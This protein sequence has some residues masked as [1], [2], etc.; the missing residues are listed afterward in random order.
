MANAKNLEELSHLAE[1]LNSQ[2]DKL[3]DSIKAL[4]VR[5]A[6]LKVGIAYWLD[7]PL[8]STGIVHGR[9]LSTPL[10]YEKNVY[11][12]YAR[13]A[14]EWQLALK[15]ETIKYQWELDSA[16]EIQKP[17]SEFEY[18]PLLSGSRDKRLKAV[19]HFDELIDG[20]TRHV[21]DKLESVKAAENFAKL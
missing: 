1:Q 16:E 13:I 19:A 15:E 10:K 8:D 6:N 9:S 7:T 20:L 11:L 14:G 17:V 2:T 21:A 18:K 12:G 3:N 4:N 5:L